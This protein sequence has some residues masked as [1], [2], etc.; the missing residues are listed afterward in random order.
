MVA[1]PHRFN[2][3]HANSSNAAAANL[4]FETQ[5]DHA[6]Q[7]LPSHPIARK[8]CSQKR[9]FL[10]I[11]Y[12]DCCFDQQLIAEV[13]ISIAFLA[14][15]PVFSIESAAPKTGARFVLFPGTKKLKLVF[16]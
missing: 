16:H 9:Q 6:N 15:A 1:T 14:A 8:R 11:C 7:V 4:R 12:A 13:R 3:Y 10:F 5:Q 2:K